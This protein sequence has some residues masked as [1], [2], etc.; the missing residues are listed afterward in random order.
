MGVLSTTDALSPW[1]PETLEVARKNVATS[2]R[3]F[4]P[5][6]ARPCPASSHYPHTSGGP[7]KRHPHNDRGSGPTSVTTAG[8]NW[9]SA[10][11]CRN[12]LGST[13]ERRA[14]KCDHCDDTFISWNVYTK[15]MKRHRGIKYK[16][17]QCCLEF[18]DLVLYKIHFCSLSAMLE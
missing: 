1:P 17:Y 9:P 3:P 4:V 18:T 6:A 2:D 13:R 7:T 11:A 5:S 15:H 16:C 12:T 10:R 8:R 14:Y